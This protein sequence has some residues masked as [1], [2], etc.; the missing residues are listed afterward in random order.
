MI[1]TLRS[2]LT[3][4]DAKTAYP[5]YLRCSELQR[6]VENFQRGVRNGQPVEDGTWRHTDPKRV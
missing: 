5:C 6:M 4:G 1:T 3:L 2:M